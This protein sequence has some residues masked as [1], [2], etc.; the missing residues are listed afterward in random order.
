MT[1]PSRRPLA[2]R[3]TAWARA[4]VRVLSRT[5]I[6]PNQIS[7]ASLVCACLAGLALWGAGQGGGAIRVLCLVVAM[8]GCQL[9]LV[10]NLLDGMLAIEAGRSTPDGAFWNEFPDRLSDT[11]IFVGLGLGL[12]SPALGWAAACLAVLTAYVRELGRAVGLTAD[13][14]GPMG[15]PQRMAVVTL[16]AGIAIFEPLW[17]DQARVLHWTLWIVCLGAALTVLR[18]AHRLRRAL[19]AS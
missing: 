5:S 18:R 15:K 4:L 14:S 7:A 17:S 16:G 2:S 8:L 19:N 3:D 6:T 9:R 1:V 10:C 11:A 13:F 12:A